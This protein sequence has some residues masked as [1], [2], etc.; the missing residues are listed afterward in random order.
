MVVEDSIFSRTHGTDPQ[1]GIDIE[2]SAGHPWFHETNITFRRCSF[3]YNQASAFMIDAGDLLNTSTAFTL[4][5]EDWHERL[6][7]P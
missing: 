4:L 5:V 3:L 6:H 1:G 2:P 7:A